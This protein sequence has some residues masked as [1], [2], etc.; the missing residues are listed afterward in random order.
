MLPRRPST[1]ELGRK[2]ASRPRVHEKT[3]PLHR[4]RGE[5]IKPN[6]HES[7]FREKSERPDAFAETPKITERA[8][9]ATR[10]EVNERCLPCKSGRSLTAAAQLPVVLAGA[11]PGASLAGG[12]QPSAK[13]IETAAT[14]NTI[15]IPRNIS[16]PLAKGRRE[17]KQ[18]NP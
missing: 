6:T 10:V 2:Y 12:A 1:L 17:G 8:P 4:G 7:R 9:P 13:V 15:R 5:L 18:P 16:I 14:V 3:A 11:W